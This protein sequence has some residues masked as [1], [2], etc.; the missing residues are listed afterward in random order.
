MG[1]RHGQW[2]LTGP[3][4]TTFKCHLLVFITRFSVSSL[5]YGTPFLL[6]LCHVHRKLATSCLHCELYLLI[7]SFL[8]T[9]TVL[10]H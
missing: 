2:Q 5:A 6:K 8:G 7:F 4:A 10:A 9:C 1:H 3:V